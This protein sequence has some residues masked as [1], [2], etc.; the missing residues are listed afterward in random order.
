M[1]FDLQTGE[2]TVFQADAVILAAGGHTRLWRRSTSRRD[3]NTG[4]GFVLALQA[5]TQLAN[6]EF[7]QFH[8]TGMVMPEEM[9]G[10]FQKMFFMVAFHALGTPEP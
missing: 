3:E 6:M 2:R 8:P 9:A 4:D 10:M 7:V 1:A 5:G